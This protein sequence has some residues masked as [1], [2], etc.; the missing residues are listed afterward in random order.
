MKFFVLSIF[1]LPFVALAHPGIGIVK[2]SKGHIY[3]TD[4]E[5]VWKMVNGKRTVAVPK[6]HT[7]E[8]YMDSKDQ[9]WGQ[10]ERYDPSRETFHH[11]LWVLR[12]GGMLDTVVGEREAYINIDFSLAR[13]REGNEYYTKQFLKKRDSNHI[14]RKTPNGK[15]T[16]FAKGI[17]NHVKWLHPQADGSLLFH[18]QNAIYR[19]DKYGHIHIIANQVASSKPSF[20]FSG[21]TPAIWGLWED[22]DANVYAAVFSD[23]AVRKIA[24]DGTISTVHTSPEHWTPLQGVFDNEGQLWVMEASDR[25]A[26]RVVRASS[27]AANHGNKALIILLVSGGFLLLIGSYLFIRKKNNKWQPVSA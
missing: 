5:Q 9:L 25:N 19:A 10:H 11:Y 23:Q 18:Q 14:Y 15:E 27:T 8:L 1:L 6:V 3:Y 24:K 16:I 21:N 17:F 4:L 22:A 20:A 12:P 2:D 26:V 7:H 13:D